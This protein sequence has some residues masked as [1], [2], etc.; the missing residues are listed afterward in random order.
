VALE[1]GWS[2][3]HVRMTFSPYPVRVHSSPSSGVPPLPSVICGT[4]YHPGRPVHGRSRGSTSRPGP[5]RA[6][7][8]P[9]QPGRAIRAVA[10]FRHSRGRQGT[11]A[12]GDGNG[13]PTRNGMPQVSLGVKPL[14]A[15]GHLV[16]TRQVTF[17]RR[18]ERWVFNHDQDTASR[19]TASAP[20]HGADRSL[21]QPHLGS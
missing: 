4:R 20:C 16:R 17:R 7:I 21:V 2:P 12:D 6:N 9:C 11:R 19:C 1:R 5:T 15:A 14:T 10:E 13:R 3:S 18:L 8:S